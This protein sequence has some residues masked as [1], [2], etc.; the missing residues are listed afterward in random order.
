MTTSVRPNAGSLGSRGQRLPLSDSYEVD[1]V[2]SGPRRARHGRS[3]APGSDRGGAHR[4]PPPACR[5]NRAGERRRAAGLGHAARHRVRRTRL[6]RHERPSNNYGTDPSTRVPRAKVIT[7][8]NAT[9]GSQA[10]G[11][12]RFGA[13]SAEDALWSAATNP[14]DPYGY[15]IFDVDP[16]ERPGE[17]TITMQ[18]FAIPAV[19]NRGG[20]LHDGTTTLLGQAVRDRR[21]RPRHLPPARLRCARIQRHHRL[22]TR[23]IPKACR[24]DA[25]LMRRGQQVRLT[26][27]FAGGS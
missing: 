8:R 27:W 3:A 9:S 11:Y 1:L 18:F 5:D 10:A 7:R 20:P 15:A 12:R 25:G 21:L 6:R 2:V 23:G 26:V 4:H 19:S 13:D 24:Y 14:D 17:T 16:G 22:A